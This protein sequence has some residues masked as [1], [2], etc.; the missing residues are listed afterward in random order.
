[1]SHRLLVPLILLGLC[2]QAAYA[3]MSF[4]EMLFDTQLQER[5]LSEEERALIAAQQQAA[6]DAEAKRLHQQQQAEQQRQQEEARRL[7][8]RPIGVQLTER[9][10]L[11]CHG[12]ETIA[13][14]HYGLPGWHLTVARM[15]YWHQVPLST[16]EAHQIS[17]Y[18]TQTQQAKPLRHVLEYL[19]I[20][21]MPLL[22]G[23]LLYRRYRHKRIPS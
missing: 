11:S 8:T 2:Q 12:M 14:K 19:G 21:S 22:A 18:L 23:I 5:T 20:I 17:Q 7:A 6:R 15:R 9:H 3:G 1:V 4:D 16:A 10:C 13:A